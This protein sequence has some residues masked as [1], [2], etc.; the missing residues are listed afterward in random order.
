V[1]ST[2]AQLGAIIRRLREEQGLSIEALAAEADISWRYLSQLELGEKQRN[3]SWILAGRIAG[4]LGL[5][6]SELAR[7]AEELVS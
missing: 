3:P 5:E 2:P 4:A 6:V 7:H 1:P